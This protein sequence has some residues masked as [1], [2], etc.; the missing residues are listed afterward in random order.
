MKNKFLNLTAVI[1]LMTSLFGCVSYQSAVLSVPETQK[2]SG[3]YHKVMPKETLWR[4]AKAY[5]VSLDEIVR[6][7][8][9]PDATKIEKGQLIFIPGVS[10]IIDLDSSSSSSVKTGYFIWPVKGKVI[11]YYGE[12]ISGRVNKGIDIN[13]TSGEDVLA[14]KSGKVT[15]LGDLKGYGKTIIIDH[16]DNFSTVYANIANPQVKLN[17]NVTQG[18]SLAKVDKLNNGKQSF[19]HFEIRK[20][21]SSQN[22]M[23]YLP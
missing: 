11:C 3:V 17:K 9:I 6:A 10:Q 1:I 20:G 16:G 23:F 22:P 19:I 12:R 21:Y 4:I 15:F 13:A 7:N 18:F 5:D 8:R 2:K 14:S